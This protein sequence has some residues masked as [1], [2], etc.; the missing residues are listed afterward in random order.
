FGIGERSDIGGMAPMNDVADGDLTDLSA[1]GA[2]NVGHLHDYA[3][4]VVGAGMFAHAL[5]DPLPQRIGQDQGFA[6]PHEEH[7]A[8][9]TRPLARLLRHGDALDDVIELLHLPVDLRGANANAAGIQRRVA[10]AQDDPAVVYR[11]LDPV[12]MPPRAG[13]S[14]EIRGVVER[15]PRVV[16]ET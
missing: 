2:R 7:D 16:P 4:H 8:H 12:A 13:E 1:D 5:P 9:V 3:G 14:L 15:A 6:Q 10:A 11:V